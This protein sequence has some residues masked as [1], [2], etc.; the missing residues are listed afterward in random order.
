MINKLKQIVNRFE[1]LEK[2][3]ID[4]E[5]LS[6]NVKVIEISK[7]RSSLEDVV[8]QSREYIALIEQIEEYKEILNGDDEELKQSHIF[9][10]KN[11][12]SYFLLCE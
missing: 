3:L 6:D 12:Q 11:T 10:L 9:Y 1:E 4:P 5:I 7:E 2:L 8:N